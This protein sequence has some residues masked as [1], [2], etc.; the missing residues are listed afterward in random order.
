[1]RK[2]RARTPVKKT[3]NIPE[4]YL[5]IPICPVLVEVNSERR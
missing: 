1:M 2:R 4:E 5:S 3:R